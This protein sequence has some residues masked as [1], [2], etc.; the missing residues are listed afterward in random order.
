MSNAKGIY[1]G[2][3]HFRNSSDSEVDGLLKSALIAVDTNVLLNLYRYSDQ[4]TDDMLDALEK[5]ADRLF[6]PNQVMAEFWRNREK[7]IR[8]LGTETQS[9]TKSLQKNCKSTKDAIS[10]WANGLGLGEDETAELWNDIEEF[11]EDLLGKVTGNYNSTTKSANTNVDEIL[12]RLEKVLD[13]T[14]G[15]PYSPERFK[16][17]AQEGN[18][19]AE[20]QIPP[21]YKDYGKIDSGRQEG[22]AGDYIVWTQLMAEAGDKGLDLVFVTGDLKE[23]WWHRGGNGEL[24]GARR[25]LLKEFRDHTDHRLHLME[26]TELLRNPQV[27]GVESTSKALAEV[28]RT[29]HPEQAE[30]LWSIDDCE[31]VLNALDGEDFPQADVIREAIESEDGMVDRER[32]YEIAGRDENVTLRGFTKP[33]SRMVAKLQEQGSLPSGLEPLLRAVYHEGVRSSHF[34]VPEE[35]VELYAE[36]EEE[37]LDAEAE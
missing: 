11:Y 2:F 3:E 26:P 13:G 21:G 10:R 18:R 27:F 23:D 33:V 4:T 36:W 7:V 28:A 6:I 5:V 17:V 1:D 20:E 22:A 34:A 9:T 12:S 14:V 8:E 37:D 30:A 16:A 29:Q 24:L 15:D 32:V 25:E 19:R 31:V 35:L